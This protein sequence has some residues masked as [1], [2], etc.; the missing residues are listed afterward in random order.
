MN[1]NITQ[2]STAQPRS[3]TRTITSNSKLAVIGLGL[4]AG[5]AY[6]FVEFSNAPINESRYG[7]EIKYNPRTLESKDK[8]LL[9]KLNK[10]LTVAHRFGVP[11]V[12]ELEKLAPLTLEDHRSIAEKRQAKHEEVTAQIKSD[13]AQ[14]GDQPQLG[15]SGFPILQ[16]LKLQNTDR[17]WS[18]GYLLYTGNRASC[19]AGA[20]KF[21]GS[22]VTKN[23]YTN[24]D[25]WKLIIDTSD[26]MRYQSKF[27]ARVAV[28][29]YR[30]QAA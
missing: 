14:L 27:D 2:T 13:F 18:D 7:V 15:Y 12:S 26:M 9:N 20:N 3:Q 5:I 22:S 4:I 21:P 8:E 19:L 11:A 6:Q 16:G 1:Q 10:K 28:T 30:Q 23:G 29:T 17:V 25:A 24:L